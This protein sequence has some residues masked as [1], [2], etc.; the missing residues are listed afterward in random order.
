M[1]PDDASL[2]QMTPDDVTA[3]LEDDDKL[4]LLVAR[5]LYKAKFPL[6]RWRQTKEYLKNEFIRRA[7]ESMERI[8]REDARLGPDPVFHGRHHI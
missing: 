2:R 5:I 8:K 1:T 3:V 7:R 4:V 6:R